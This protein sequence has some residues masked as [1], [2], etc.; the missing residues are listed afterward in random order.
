MIFRWSDEV[1]KASLAFTTYTWSTINQPTWC[2][3]TNGGTIQV[4]SQS[5]RDY[6]KTFTGLKGVRGMLMA[7]AQLA[8]VVVILR[9]TFIFALLTLAED[10]LRLEWF[11]LLPSAGSQLPATDSSEV[12]W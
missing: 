12:S 4:I 8:R 7:K 9:S 2:L 10:L 5:P 11:S 3:I 6:F 1:V